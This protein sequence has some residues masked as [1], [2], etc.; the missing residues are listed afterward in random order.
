MPFGGAMQRTIADATAGGL[1][2]VQFSQRGFDYV[3]DLQ[4]LTQLNVHT[5][6][7]RKVRKTEAT[8]ATA[9]MIPDPSKGP[10]QL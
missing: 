1:T 4:K 3:L 7:I 5:G 6:K 2:T 9:T 10:S 8:N